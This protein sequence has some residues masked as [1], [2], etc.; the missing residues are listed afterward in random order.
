MI[1]NHC[2]WHLTQVSNPHIVP[3]RIF[4][5]IHSKSPLIIWI[6]NLTIKDIIAMQSDLKVTQSYSIHWNIDW[7]FARSKY[8][9]IQK[10]YWFLVHSKWLHYKIEA[11]EIGTTSTAN[12]HDRYYWWCYF[13]WI[14]FLI[15]KKIFLFIVSRSEGFYICIL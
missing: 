1:W 10:E 8:F 15:S 4:I 14:Y 6:W 11:T 13:N 7:A 5:I 12:R 2:F 3:V 9:Q